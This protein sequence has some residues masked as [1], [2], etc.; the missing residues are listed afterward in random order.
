[1]AAVFLAGGAA[2]LVYIL[3]GLSLRWT[4]LTL[5][6]T[7][8]VVATLVIRGRSASRRAWILRRMAVGAFAGLI[9]T[10]GYDVVRVALVEF[11]GFVLK[12]FE[13]W[14]LFGMALAETESSS[15]AIFVLG[16]AFHLCNGIAF[17]VAYTVAFGRAGIV[18]GIIW[19][20]VLETF[21]VSV[22]PGWL[23]LKALD[24]FLSVSIT[25]HLV[26]GCLLGG[27]AAWLLGH[28][29]WREYDR[30][31]APA[32]ADSTTADSTTPDSPAAG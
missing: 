27:V 2:L 4:F 6:L 5:G 28:S 23:G 3:A 19:A 16:T 1:V 31:T 24:E 10:I 8:A 21:M 26:Y 17:G 22:Y 29:R 15:T 11:A 12:P 30:V 32:T 14:R 20:L 18:A 7:A 25:G 13:A 9:A